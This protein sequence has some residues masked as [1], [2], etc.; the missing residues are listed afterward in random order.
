V[1]GLQRPEHVQA[2]IIDA[3]REPPAA[4]STVASSARAPGVMS[5]GW[6]VMVLSLVRFLERCKT[7]AVDA[8][9]L[10]GRAGA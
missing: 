9:R 7:G 3:G 1:I 4:A 2:D 5:P 6:S 10:V 8:R